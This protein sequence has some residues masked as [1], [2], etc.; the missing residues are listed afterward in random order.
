[1]KTKTEQILKVMHVLAWVAFIG[2]LIQTGTILVVYVISYFTPDAAND[3]H[4]GMNLSTLRQQ[5]F[6]PLTMYI[7]FVISIW[8][9][10]AYIAFLL[11]QTLSKMN[12]SNPF[13]MEVATKL[14]TI[15]HLL[16]GMAVICVIRNGYTDWLVKHVGEFES[17]WGAGE[18]V[19]MAG[20]V[21]IIAQ[22]FKR[23]VEIQSENDLTV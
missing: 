20:L 18:Y 8:A 10:K 21:F 7:S 1:M 9:M 16:I 17:K 3:F 23:G 4:N 6:Y 22:I 11:T 13:T 2:L 12:L 14:E 19:F 5:G 15:S